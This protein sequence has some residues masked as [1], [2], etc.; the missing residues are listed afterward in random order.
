MPAVLS[1]RSEKVLQGE[2]DDPVNTDN[3]DDDDDKELVALDDVADRNGTI[4]NM[5]GRR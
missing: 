2:E 3:E 4:M 1:A 5:L